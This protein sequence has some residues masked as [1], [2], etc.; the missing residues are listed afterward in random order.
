M[1]VLRREVEPVAE[2]AGSWLILA[3]RQGVGREVA[4]WLSARN[5]T[6][7]LVKPGDQYR[8]LEDAY[9]Q[10]PLEDADSWRRL[11]SESLAQ[12]KPPLRGVVHLWSL[13]AADA[14]STTADSLRR[15]TQLSCG[16]VLSLVQAL[17]RQ[18]QLPSGGLWLVTHGAQVVSGERCT[19]PAQSAL[20]GL[21]KVVALEHPELKCRCVD[22]D[23]ANVAADELDPLLEELLSPDREDQL[24]FRGPRR[25]APRL[26]RSGQGDSLSLPSE[27][28]FRLAKAADRTLESLHF[29]PLSLGELGSG[30]VQLEIQ[31][32]G[33]N[34]RDVLDALG[35]YPGDIG[36][37]GGEVAGVVRAVG[38]GVDEFTVS[39]EVV[40]FAWGAFGNCVNV[41][42]CLLAKRQARLRPVE[43]VTIPIAFT[44]VQIAFELAD[45]KA[46][47]RVLI[48]AASGG[49]GLAAI[50]L[51]RSVGA[52]VFATASEPKQAYLRSLG[53]KHIYNSRTREFAEQLLADTDGQGVDVVVNSLTRGR[54]Y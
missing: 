26:V 35:M 27:G 17:V 36:P 38:A 28:N 13:D 3:D 41:P 21:G 54:F 1:R 25:L 9:Y 2:E 5:Q 40:G 39:D 31:A 51:A 50:Q 24:A 11:L 6:C 22:L 19:S 10:V 20:W 44:T 18:D 14:E 53:V 42:A 29:E 49:V 12:E 4:E 48:H 34:F 32:A 43:A 23:G 37:L 33:L 45:L 47:D 8:Q 15:D 46:D 16:S 7:A 30:E 52:E